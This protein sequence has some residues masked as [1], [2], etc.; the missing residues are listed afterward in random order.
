MDTSAGSRVTELGAS[1]APERLDE[2]RERAGG[3]RK[4]L[5]RAGTPAEHWRQAVM[6]ANVGTLNGG[7]VTLV[8]KLPVLK[9]NFWNSCIGEQLIK[10][11]DT[12]TSSAA[13]AECEDHA[14][15]GTRQPDEQGREPFWV[16]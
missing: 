3:A 12:A 14:L 15:L 2:I 16:T 5:Q 4:H 9:R 8:R 11:C 13:S 6:P 10:I 1:F 7:L